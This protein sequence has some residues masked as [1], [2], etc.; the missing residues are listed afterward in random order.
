SIPPTCSVLFI[1]DGHK[2]HINYTSVNFCY[3][4]NILFYALPPHTI[5]VLQ[6]AELLFSALKNAYDKKCERYQVNNDG[7]L[8]MKYT[9]AKVIGHSY[10]ATYIPAS[11]CNAFKAMGIWPFNP[12]AIGSDHLEPS[13]ATECTNLLQIPNPL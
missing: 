11:I 6:P 10:I 13:L 2:S 5:Y 8:D 1:L 3:E 9:F 4:N 7:K 12:S